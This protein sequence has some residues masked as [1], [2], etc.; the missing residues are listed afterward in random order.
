MYKSNDF[1]STPQIIPEVHWGGGHPGC[2]GE[3]RS[4]RVALGVEWA[5]ELS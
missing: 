4:S 5:P 3:G 2:L 1:L